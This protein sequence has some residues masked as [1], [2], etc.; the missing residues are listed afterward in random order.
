M[1]EEATTI[2]LSKDAQKIL[3]LV[4]NLSAVDL[5]QLVK[6]LEEE[7]G[8]S[9]AAPVMMWGWGGAWGDDDGGSDSVTVE[10]AEVG[11]QKI[12]VIKAV[13]EI[14]GLGLK[15]AKEIVEKAP[16]PVKE[17]IPAE[18]AEAIKA[19]LEE[20]GATVALK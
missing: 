18:E 1:T 20:A 13:K 3:D 2:E 14:L 6:A 16:A 10:L 12:A 9:A 19:K 8:V 11:Q 4:K 7:F 15:E 5:N 17:N